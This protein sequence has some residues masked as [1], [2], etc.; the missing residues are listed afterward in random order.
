M[1]FDFGVVGKFRDCSTGS[2]SPSPCD[3]V[4]NFTLFIS[5]ISLFVLKGDSNL[6]I[7]GG[8]VIRPFMLDPLGVNE[9]LQMCRGRL[10]SGGSAVVSFWSSDHGSKS[11]VPSQHNTLVASKQTLI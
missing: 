4:Q 2:G 7:L 9:I 8:L 3:C 5:R 11:K 1:V 10:E 6:T